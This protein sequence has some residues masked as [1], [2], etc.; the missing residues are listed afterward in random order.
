MGRVAAHVAA[1][2]SVS[3]RAERVR[4]CCCHSLRGTAENS[5][6]RS[7]KVSRT[8]YGKLMGDAMRAVA[9]GGTLPAVT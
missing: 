9:R 3:Q 7:A 1:V 5:G 8:S 4:S 2:P 6:V